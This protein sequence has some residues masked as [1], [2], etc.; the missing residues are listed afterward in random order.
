MTL[1][2]EEC[3]FFYAA[4]AQLA[5]ELRPMLYREGREHSRRLLT[6]LRARAGRRRSRHPTGAGR[7]MDS[8]SSRRG[9]ERLA[10]ESLDARV[11][12]NVEAGLLRRT[13]RHGDGVNMRGTVCYHFATQL[14]STERDQVGRGG[15]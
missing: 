14:G 13:A 4:Q 3:A 15:T 6:I 1:P 9:E 8:A 7:L 12:T 5:P 10:M 11:R 2:P